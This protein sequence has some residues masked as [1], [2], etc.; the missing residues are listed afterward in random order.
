MNVRLGSNCERGVPDA[1]PGAD[2]PE[3]GRP[4]LSE[5]IDELESESQPDPSGTDA[6]DTD[7]LLPPPNPTALD[8]LDEASDATA[9][10]PVAGRREFA[11]APPRVRRWV[12]PV[13]I[14][15]VLAVLAGVSAW[16]WTQHSSASDWKTQA[17]ALDADL[18][19]TRVDLNDTQAALAKSEHELT[20]TRQDLTE[21]ETMLS[22][23]R[24]QI[25]AVT[26]KLATATAQVDSLTTERDS[27]VAQVGTLA[28]DKAQ[29][30]DERAQL[31]AVLATAPAVTVALRACVTSNTELSIELLNVIE[32]YPYRS[33]DRASR[34]VD[35]TVDLCA[36][37]LAKTNDFES[38]LA[39][40]GV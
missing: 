23:A 29:I 39:A 28:N 25:T 15:V 4:F 18:T 10:V 38:T 11:P 31:S 34:M 22:E 33:L 26:G 20:G 16:G 9:L 8:N 17:K 19:S 14:G 35:N 21:T 3:I 13:T 12:R 30:E 24:D 2:E 5:M 32:A 1:L 37:A 7:T 6:H 27:L 40:F 36:D